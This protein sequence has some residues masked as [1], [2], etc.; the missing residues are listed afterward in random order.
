V[1]SPGKVL[2][3]PLSHGPTSML[4][5]ADLILYRADEL[6]GLRAAVL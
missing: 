6:A 3:L 2:F 1:L 5:F 4:L